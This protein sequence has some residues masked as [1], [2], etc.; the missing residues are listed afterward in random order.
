MPTQNAWFLV[1]V[2]PGQTLNQAANINLD[3]S[4]D[5]SNVIAMKLPI[6]TNYQSVLDNSGL[7][8]YYDASLNVQPFV[9]PH[10]RVGDAAAAAQYFGFLM[11]L[12]TAGPSPE[13]NDFNPGIHWVGVPKQ[14]HDTVVGLTIAA[15][16]GLWVY[17]N[18]YDPAAASPLVRDGVPIVTFPTITYTQ[19]TAAEFLPGDAVS[20]SDLTLHI[21]GANKLDPENNWDVARIRGY[22]ADG[23]ST[24]NLNLLRVTDG[25]FKLN[26]IYGAFWLYTTID[27]D[28]DM[29]ILNAMLNSPT[30]K[31]ITD[32]NGV[33]GTIDP[34]L[35]DPTFDFQPISYGTYAASSYQALILHFGGVVGRNT[36]LV[37]LKDFYGNI[38]LGSHSLGEGMSGD[39][40]RMGT[41]FNLPTFDFAHLQTLYDNAV[42]AAWGQHVQASA[43]PTN[44]LHSTTPY[45]LDS[46]FAM[47]RNSPASDTSLNVVGY[48]Q[49]GATGVADAAKA[50]LF[51]DALNHLQD[52]SNVT[53]NPGTA[54]I[55]TLTTGLARR[56]SW[57]EDA[58]LNW[59]Y[60]PWSGTEGYL[61]AK[62]YD[63][64]TQVALGYIEPR[65]A[66]DALASV[67]YVGYQQTDVSGN[68]TVAGIDLNDFYFGA[69][70]AVK[71]GSYNWIRFETALTWSHIPYIVADGGL[72][73]DTT[74]TRMAVCLKVCDS[75]TFEMNTGRDLSNNWVWGSG[76]RVTFDKELFLGWGP[77]QNGGENA[78]DLIYPEGFG[79]GHNTFLAPADADQTG[80]SNIQFNSGGLT[81]DNTKPHSTL[82]NYV[83]FKNETFLPLDPI[84]GPIDL[85]MN[86]LVLQDPSGGEQNMLATMSVSG[87]PGSGTV[88][89]PYGVFN[90]FWLCEDAPNGAAGT[91]FASTSTGTP[92]YIQTAAGTGFNMS[93]TAPRIDTAGAAVNDGSGN[94][95]MDHKYVTK[96]IHLDD[97]TTFTAAGAL[98]NGADK[99]K[100]NAGNFDQYIYI[101]NGAVGFGTT[102][103]HQMDVKIIAQD[104][105]VQR[106]VAANGEVLVFYM[107]DSIWST[108]S[109]ALYKGIQGDIKEMGA[110]GEQGSAHNYD[111]YFT[112]WF[113]EQLEWVAYGDSTNS[114]LHAQGQSADAGVLEGNTPWGWGYGSYPN[115][116]P[117]RIQLG[118][119][120]KYIRLTA[121]QLG[122]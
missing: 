81:G 59:G 104:P 113:Q 122:L 48:D 102:F 33:G 74:N 46:A 55:H 118:N 22:P 36:Y 5:G 71:A 18:N 116:D 17:V 35:L 105:D 79:Y 120:A 15:H 62:P 115:A 12:V 29:F 1:S 75:M 53:L 85:I 43:I 106:V 87:T 112:S 11:N 111:S 90:S 84:A 103:T 78:T 114:H 9:G 32:L 77:A 51:V 13:R 39:S 86:S 47:M 83:Y 44:A 10:S 56:P 108:A 8:P 25:T 99:Q 24:V 98:E 88:Q 68:V 26:A 96:Q 37:L 57:W 101:A 54:V 82:T 34:V 100:I 38:T 60:P 93:V 107:Y 30:N 27:G 31:T 69:T 58:M 64:I 97:S 89:G 3:V 6:A 70:A 76:N 41:G 65:Q 94:Q 52:P 110:A 45:T 61:L 28:P 95:Y 91:S 73:A 50:Q 117:A 63:L 40:S 49:L 4:A 2:A 67:G 16:M 19:T 92:F 72:H 21:H 121:A 119:N 42:A 80:P 14:C 20:H 7:N 66:A 23:S 109:N